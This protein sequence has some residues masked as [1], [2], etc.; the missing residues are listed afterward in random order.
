MHWILE[1]LTNRNSAQKRRGRR[2]LVVYTMLGLPVCGLAAEPKAPSLRVQAS[3]PVGAQPA[4]I[5]VVREI[6]DPATGKRWLLEF[7][8]A[9]PGGPGRLVLASESAAVPGKRQAKIN[10][11]VSSLPT[12][13]PSPVKAII[14]AGD[15][16]VVEQN[17][18]VIEARLEAV[19]LAPAR[20]GA[21]FQARLE[22]GGKVVR[23]VAIAP[24]R[25]SLAPEIPVW[26]GGWR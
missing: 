24:G 20:K 22:I 23:A 17:T 18:R 26:R 2:L 14:R 6:D 19:A 9:H 16:L 21:T 11:P 4:R 25:A 7:D 10:A 13:V 12:A 8:P 3:S 15:R 1:G 5:V